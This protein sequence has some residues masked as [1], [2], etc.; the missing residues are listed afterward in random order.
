MKK[1]L[2]NLY[3]IGLYETII[4]FTLLFFTYTMPMTVHRFSS[5]FFGKMIIIISIVFASYHSLTY[6]IILTVLFIGIS[7]LGKLEEGYEII[8][9]KE[10]TPFEK[11]MYDSAKDKFINKNCVSTKTKFNLDTIDKDYKELVFS[12]GAC[13]PCDKTCRYSISNTSANLSY[14]DPL[15]KPSVD[16][17]Y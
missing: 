8:T 2:L 14:F 1:H 7:E 4:M 6:G 17:V 12:D 11:K 10:R 13:D 15:I 5:S 3:E 16:K 9:N